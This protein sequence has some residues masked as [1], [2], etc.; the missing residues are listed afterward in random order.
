[1]SGCY[2]STFFALC[3]VKFDPGMPSSSCIHSHFSL[4]LKREISKSI[5]LGYF[6][7]VFVADK[8]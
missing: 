2:P 8:M 7:K 1:M 3:I 5:N 4:A 6:N